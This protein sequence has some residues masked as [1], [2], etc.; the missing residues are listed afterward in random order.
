MGF[1]KSDCTETL[2]ESYIE[3]DIDAQKIYLYKDN[4]LLLSSDIVSGKNST[5]TRI[6]FLT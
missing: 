6:G 5:P 4:D 1:V 3:V 2:P